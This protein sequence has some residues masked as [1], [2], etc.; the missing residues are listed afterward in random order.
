MRIKLQ[1]HAKT[2]WSLGD[3]TIT[4]EKGDVWSKIDPESNSRS[5]VAPLLQMPIDENDIILEPTM[6]AEPAD[7][8]FIDAQNIK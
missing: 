4:F 2:Q 8:E 6:S 5:S 7:F 3:Q 1:L